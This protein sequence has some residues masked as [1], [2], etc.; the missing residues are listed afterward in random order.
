[1]FLTGA[2]GYLGSRV[3]AVLGR[4]RLSTVPTSRTGRVGE[5]CDLTD[6]GLTQALLERTAPSVVV[7][8]AAGVPKSAS[9]YDDAGAAEASAAM[10]KTL[11]RHA[12]CPI[13]FAS[14]MTVYGTHPSCPVT[15]DAELQPDSAYARGKVTAERLL[16][17]RQM[18]GD[19]ALRLPGLFGLPRR[20]GLLYNAAKA[21]LTG[22]RFDVDV[23]KTS[24]AAMSVDD[25]AEY[26]VKAALGPSVGSGQAVNV[27]YDGEF[28][29][30]SA[31][32]ELAALC[33]VQWRPST[34]GSRP[35]SMRLDRLS[36]RYGKLPVTFSQ[37][38]AELVN[39]V[40]RDLT[41]E[42]SVRQ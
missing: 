32:A 7:H 4:R 13:V 28:S 12:R 17:D 21:F 9:A 35:F 24:W 38:L 22:G 20:S 6:D 5:P 14:S 33:G 25:A 40:R 11:A 19:A 18:A 16:S 10:T 42:S 34:A 31:V 26:L 23:P 2:S 37:R 36:S 27:G 41:V 15:E 30:P 3:L 39:A 29:V 1:V 8:C